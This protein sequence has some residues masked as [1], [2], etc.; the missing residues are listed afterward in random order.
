MIKKSRRQHPL[1]RATPKT[2]RYRLF[3]IA[4]RLVR[5]ARRTILRI[6]AT[7]PWA[8][9]ASGAWGRIVALC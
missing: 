3:H 8:A 1:A 2:L 7:W 6:E 4:G 5:H 9:T